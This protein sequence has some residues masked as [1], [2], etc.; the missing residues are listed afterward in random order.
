MMTTVMY[1]HFAPTYF[2]SK[3][4]H[5]FVPAVFIAQ[6]ENDMPSHMSDKKIIPGYFLL[7]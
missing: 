7:F 5:F 2:I 1:A 4:Q 3:L 6:E